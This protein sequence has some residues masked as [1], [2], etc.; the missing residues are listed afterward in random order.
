MK[1][2]SRITIIGNGNVGGHFV[3]A[4]ELAGLEVRK[5]PA[6]SEFKTDFAAD[7]L[8]LIAVKDDYIAEI[9]KRL[10]SLPLQDCGKSI[11]VHT[12]GSVPMSV[13]DPLLTVN[14]T[15]GVFYPM[16]TFTKD[17][18]MRYDDIPFLIEASDEASL[19][20]LS[21]IASRISKNVLRADSQVRA[22]YHIAAVFTCNFSNHLCA[23]ADEYLQ[24]NGLNFKLLLPL[25]RQTVEK[26]NHL[27]PRQAQT[28]PAKRGDVKVMEYHLRQL[29]ENPVL[30]EVY[31]NLSESII[32]F[33]SN[34]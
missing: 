21:R 32:K 16:Q 20:L 17:S 10:A 1:S 18:P 30:S 7:S 6:R 28:G 3:N 8:I 33:Q 2:I 24:S 4:F 19:A 22:A 11:V 5:V 27:S 12:S 31:K 15:V 23:M 9:V 13:L 26:L 34:E 25:L 14:R 29:E